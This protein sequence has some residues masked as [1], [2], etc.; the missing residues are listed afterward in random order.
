MLPDR[1]V[2][3]VEIVSSS[4][5]CMQARAEQY[6][7]ELKS[8]ENSWQFFLQRV[9]ETSHDSVA[10]WCLKAVQEDLQNNYVAMSQA[11]KIAVTLPCHLFCCD[12]QDPLVQ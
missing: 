10:F 8:M 1:A 6:C 4:Q 2:W 11:Q 3:T 5:H 9:N 7:K 12:I